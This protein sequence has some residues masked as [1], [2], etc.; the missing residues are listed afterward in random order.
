MDNKLL[1]VK[2][3][4][5]VYLSTLVKELSQDIH[6][7]VSD[8]LELVRPAENQIRTELTHDLTNSLRD[9]LITM[10]EESKTKLFNVDD[11]KQRYLLL[12]GDNKTIYNA[13]LSGLMTLD[14]GEDV[15]RKRATDEY[16]YVR[17]EIDKEKLIKVVNK[18]SYDMAFNKEKINWSNI[19]NDIHELIE[20]YTHAFNNNKGF[21]SHPAVIGSI[22]FNDPDYVAAMLSKAVDEMSLLG[23]LKTPYQG[24]NRMLGELGGFRRGEMLLIGAL[25]YSYKSGLSRDLFIGMALANTPYMIN[26]DKTPLMLRISL[27][28]DLNTDVIEIYKRLRHNYDKVDDRIK[29]IDPN[30]AA[31]YIK[32]KLGATG[33][34]I[35]VISAD[36]T[37]FGVS[38]IINTVDSLEA[39]G[40]E[41]HHLNVDYLA[42]SAK[43]FSRSADATSQ[44]I[45]N[46]FTKLRNYCRRK[47][48]FLST[49]HQ[50]GREAKD[51]LSSGVSDL[52]KQ[53]VG[54]SYY[55]GCKRIDQEVDVEIYI[56]KETLN[57]EDYLTMQRGKHRG[58]N[59]TPHAHQYCVYKFDPMIGLSF[60]WNGE[61]VSYRSLGGTTMSEGGDTPL[62]DA[63]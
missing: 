6:S 20:P 16:W 59:N 15:V 4:T 55:D 18:I 26:P 32:E 61:D 33:Y 34:E 38:D 29:D 63:T 62:W 39:Q 3:I 1:L 17:G 40:Y 43:N 21:E 30:E 12:A 48:I 54:K 46:M 23:I 13:L 47:K 35:K 51:L 45:Q 44:Y 5:L 22:D 58:V 60:D 27:E 24:I 57:G 41:I 8:V 37:N 10:V 25:R 50:L 2:A 28:D 49:P 53:I 52:V 9:M 11:L 14:D 36:P 42:M 56:H 31:R 19:S 7:I